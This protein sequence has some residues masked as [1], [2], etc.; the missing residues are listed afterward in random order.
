MDE[1]KVDAEA[2]EETPAVTEEAGESA[3]EASIE[4]ITG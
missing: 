3:S 1:Q 2:V 4:E